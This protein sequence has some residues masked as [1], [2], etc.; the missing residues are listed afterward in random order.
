MTY[1]KTKS[2]FSYNSGET[3]Q[4]SHIYS[5]IPHCAYYACI[6]L[7]KH[8]LIKC[9]SKD[10]RSMKVEMTNKKYNT[11]TYI[12]ETIIDNL[13]SRNINIREFRDEITQLKRLRNDADYMDLEVTSIEGTN[14]LTLS[15]RVQTFLKRNYTV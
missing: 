2:T 7:M 14:S 6:Q 13:I 3:L 5:S 12:I 4:R 15:N 9:L 8:I 1:L 11:H 10:E